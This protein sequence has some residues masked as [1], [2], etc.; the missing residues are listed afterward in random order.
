MGEAEL[1]R[2]KAKRSSADP[3]ADRL[4]VGKIEEKK[5]EIH[6]VLGRLRRA[7]SFAE[8]TIKPS[9]A[10][11]VGWYSATSDADTINR[12]MA[13]LADVFKRLPM[14]E[15]GHPVERVAE[16]FINRSFYIVRDAVASVP[17]YLLTNSCD[18]LLYQFCPTVF[19]S[20]AA[21]K[22]NDLGSRREDMKPERNDDLQAPGNCL[23]GIDAAMHQEP[24]HP[25][26]KSLQRELEPFLADFVESRG[27]QARPYFALGYASILSQL[28]Q[29]LAASAV[30][31][32]WIHMRSQR[33]EPVWDT[34][35][36]W[37]D[38]RV[39]SILVNFLEIWLKKEGASA[40]TAVRDE[41]IANLDILRLDIKSRLEQVDFFREAAASIGATPT[42]S[43]PDK[44]NSTTAR[45][46][47]HPAFREIHISIDGSD[48]SRL[49]LRQS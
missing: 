30:L 48:C 16:E 14:I 31:D 1:Q 27:W 26:F 12:H 38:L 25:V 15:S 23:R 35:A 18:A 4:L 37:F 44:S 13:A 39:R 11:L 49:T 8:M 3:E 6:A 45:E 41:H 22:L 19:R 46:I 36:D 7:K 29:N 2:Q 33:P 21:R 17:G 9:T 28:G 10:C 42:N 32:N 5:T 34:A 47:R 20:V 40:P 24:K 43:W